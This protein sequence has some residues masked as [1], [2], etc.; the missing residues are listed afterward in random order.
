MPHIFAHILTFCHGQGPR[1]HCQVPRSTMK[2]TSTG[3]TKMKMTTKTKTRTR[4]RMRP[5][6]R[7]GTLPFCASFT[8]Y[9]NPASSARDLARKRELFYQYNA[10]LKIIPD[11]KTDIHLLNDDEL[12]TLSDFVKC[13]LLYSLLTTDLVLRFRNQAAKRMVPT[14]VTSST[15]LLPTYRPLRRTTPCQMASHGSLPYCPKPCE[16]GQTFTPRARSPCQ[17]SCPSW[18]KT[19][20]SRFSFDDV[21]ASL[22]YADRFSE[23][24]SNKTIHIVA[25]DF[26]SFLFDIRLFNDD[27]FEVTDSLLRGK[28]FK[29]VCRFF[30]V[31]PSLSLMQPHHNSFTSPYGQELY[32]RRWIIAGLRR[33]RASLP[34]VFTTGSERSPHAVWH[35]PPYWC[36]YR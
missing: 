1:R 23:E 19:G 18:R 31:P 13:S 11:L 28:L 7:N 36:V 8:I 25:Q 9:M 33:P 12:E 27:D 17:T 22:T 2:Q 35:T 21:P 30:C 10:L 4:T 24:V 34:L 26:P 15:R 5:R 3:T 6:D 16:V 29:M 32:L 14:Q 20:R